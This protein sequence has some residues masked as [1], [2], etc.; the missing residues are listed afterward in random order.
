[1]VTFDQRLGPAAFV[2]GERSARTF[3]SSPEVKENPP[4]RRWAVGATIAKTP[5]GP[6]TGRATCDWRPTTGIADD[7]FFAMMARVRA[8]FLR[9]HGEVH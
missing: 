9:N 8:Q 5:W 1:V 4:L 2:A 3:A 6:T 7:G